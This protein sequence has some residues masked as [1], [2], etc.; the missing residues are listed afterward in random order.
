MVHDPSA[1]P[2]NIVRVITLTMFHSAAVSS[3]PYRA[4]NGD[5][6]SVPWR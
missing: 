3:P 4:R 5:W 1:A 2:W 6:V